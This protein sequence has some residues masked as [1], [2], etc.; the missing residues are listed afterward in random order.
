M[1]LLIWNVVEDPKNSYVD[2]RNKITHSLD[3]WQKPSF[4]TEL[5][6]QK[7]VRLE[8]E[9]ILQSEKKSDLLT[10]LQIDE[11][12][13]PYLF[14]VQL[15][16]ICREHIYECCL[17]RDSNKEQVHNG[18]VQNGLV[19]SN[20]DHDAVVALL[21]SIVDIKD[22]KEC[23]RFRNT[24]AVLLKTQGKNREANDSKMVVNGAD[25]LKEAKKEL[26]DCL[27]SKYSWDGPTVDL[28]LQDI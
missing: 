15:L 19:T 7:E 10:K 5:L 6:K 26:E 12:D 23:N 9:K 4:I 8:F 25:S 13:I 21:N 17:V 27:I 24:C 22:A 2:T 16:A 14:F 20:L 28:L 3:D 11:S 1:T 18:P